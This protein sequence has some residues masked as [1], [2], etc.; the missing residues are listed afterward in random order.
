MI[1]SNEPL[2]LT[3]NGPT[4]VNLLANTGRFT[5]GTQNVDVLVAN[6]VTR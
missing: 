1:L 6:G 5:P 3:V 2:N 4:V